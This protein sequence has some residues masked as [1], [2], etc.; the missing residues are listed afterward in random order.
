[1]KSK[2]ERVNC[3]QNMT[4]GKPKKRKGTLID[5]LAFGFAK[6]NCVAS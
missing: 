1:M 6:A 4:C 2:S 5:N 3:L